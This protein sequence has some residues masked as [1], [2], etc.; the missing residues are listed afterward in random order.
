MYAHLLLPCR[1]FDFALARVDAGAYVRANY[2]AYVQTYYSAFVQIRVYEFTDTGILPFPTG[3]L[4]YTCM[5]AWYGN[6]FMP[7]TVFCESPEFEF[8]WS[9]HFAITT[10]QRQAYGHSYPTRA[11]QHMDHSTN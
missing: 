2:S 6:L 1:F 9:I 4:T 11:V 3:V 10:Y 7:C 8:A 5:Q